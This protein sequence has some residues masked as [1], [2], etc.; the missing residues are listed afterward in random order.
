MNIR[1][2]EPPFFHLLIGSVTDL[3]NY[4]ERL[5]SQQESAVVMRLL[6]GEDMPD[7]KGFFAE[8]ASAL[9][10]PFYFGKNMNALAECLRDLE[11]WLPAE[12][13]VLVISQA[14]L[15]LREERQEDFVAFFKLL[16]DVSREWAAGTLP[17][18]NWERKPTPFHVILHADAGGA[19]TLSR[20]LKSVVGD[21]PVVESQ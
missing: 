20:I 19:D 21:I 18:A 7:S 14:T 10:F 13:Y 15:V 9:Q 5:R 11:D 1:S 12:A 3:A 8:F 2:K 17:G 4:Y 6:R 16:A